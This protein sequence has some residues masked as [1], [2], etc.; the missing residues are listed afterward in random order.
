MTHLFTTLS[1]LLA[2]AAPAAAPGQSGVLGAALGLLLGVVQFLVSLSIAAFAINKGFA[3]VS[4]MLDGLNVWAEVKQRNIA[5]A[6]LAA[7]VVISYTN[8]IGG[9]IASMTAGLG[10][11]AS[12][13]WGAG[14]AAIVGGVFN[15]VVAL[16]VA[17]FGISVTFK[18]MDRLTTDIDEKQELRSGN[19]A[20]GIVYAGIL[21]GVSSMISAGVAGIGGGL[22]HFLDTLI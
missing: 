7:G 12:A 6:L 19:V 2:T 13:D 11:F 21:V 22:T 14:V 3:L 15:L 8:V 16:L 9:G 20:I 1:P 10:S 5:V 4:R 17:G 18:V